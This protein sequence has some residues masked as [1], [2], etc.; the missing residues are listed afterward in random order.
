MP[1]VFKPEPCPEAKH[2]GDVDYCTLSDHICDLELG[3]HC[4]GHE[5]YLEG[6]ELKDIGFYASYGEEYR[7]KE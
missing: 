2:M 6:L 3:H 1:E 5:A 4:E 7:R